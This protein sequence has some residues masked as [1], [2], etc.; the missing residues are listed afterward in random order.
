[1]NVNHITHVST[2]L[3]YA[4]TVAGISFV[5]FIIAGFVQSAVISLIVGAVLTI[6]TLFVLR[7]TVGK[8]SRL[9]Y[10]EA[11]ASFA[12]ETGA[13]EIP[14]SPTRG[15]IAVEM[16]EKKDAMAVESATMGDGSIESKDSVE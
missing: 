10:A 15:E 16:A 14:V 4:L 7:N 11:A 12:S 2:Q 13:G 8:K 1:A 9:A 5:T 6:G 3:P